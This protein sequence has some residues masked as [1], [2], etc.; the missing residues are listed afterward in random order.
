MSETTKKILL[1]LFCPFYWLY[2]IYHYFTTEKCPS[3]GKRHKPIIMGSKVIE[4][5]SKL[6]VFENTIRDSERREIGTQEQIVRVNC[7]IYS[8]TYKCSH[9]G[10]IWTIE[11]EDEEM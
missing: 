4:S 10:H 5:G 8:V 9:C 2:L 11:E 6:K 7:N 3:C 1:V